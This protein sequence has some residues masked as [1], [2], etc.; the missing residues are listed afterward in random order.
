MSEPY[1]SWWAVL[2]A[3]NYILERPRYGTLSPIPREGYPKGCSV[4][5]VHWGNTFDTGGENADIT[6]M[7]DTAEWRVMPSHAEGAPVTNQE[8]LELPG[9]A[10]LESELETWTAWW[11]RGPNAGAR[12]VWS[13]DAPIAGCLLYRFSQGVSGPADTVS[14]FL[15]VQDALAALTLDLGIRDPISLAMPMERNGETPDP[16]DVRQMLFRSRNQTVI[17]HRPP[18]PQGPAG[19]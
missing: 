9:V 3:C 13:I 4:A 12:L 18:T 8:R 1:R 2:Q 15:T 6:F 5:S 7:L 16:D 14:S 17:V 10:M 19:Q 11:Y